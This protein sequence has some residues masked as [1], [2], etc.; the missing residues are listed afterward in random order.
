MANGIIQLMNEFPDTCFA[1]QIHKWD[2][3]STN[4][5]GSRWSFYN[6]PGPP[7]VWL[8]GSL[9]LTGSQG[10]VAANYKSLRSKYIQ[11]SA[12]STDVTI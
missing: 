12:T 6:V 3:Y 9:N 8:D 10:S 7:T 2:S 11:L 4:W 5:G 1:M